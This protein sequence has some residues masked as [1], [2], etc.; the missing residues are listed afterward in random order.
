MR[1]RT[2]WIVGIALISLLGGCRPG[3]NAH[4]SQVAQQGAPSNLT[5]R[6]ASAPTTQAQPPIGEF[7]QRL[8]DNGSI[9]F[10][11]YNGKAYRMD[12]DLEIT[13]FPGGRAHV[14]DYG[15]S[16][17][18]HTG[19]YR[20]EPEGRI[21]AEFKRFS[22]GHMAMILQRDTSSLLLRPGDHH[23]RYVLGNDPDG[24][25]PFRP[26]HGDDEREVI[27]RVR[28]DMSSSK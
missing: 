23:T 3:S 14:F 4:N 22:D 9:T 15:L 11:S 16:L 28:E 18:G 5:L 24:F 17:E 20:V 12:C 25:W 2:L 10:R 13:F 8:A 27:T 26:I 7:R 19:S 6:T 21:T 1:K